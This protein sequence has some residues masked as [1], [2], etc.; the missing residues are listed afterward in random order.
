[1][2]QFVLC[3]E[4]HSLQRRIE[5]DKASYWVCAYANS[6]HDLSKDV[7]ED[8]EQSSFRKAMRLATGTLLM[9]DPAATAFK[10]IWCNFEL[11]K[12]VTDLNKLLDIATVRI[13][14]THA[15]WE[16]CIL[17]HGLSPKEASFKK[18]VREQRFPLELLVQGVKVRLE[19]GTATVDADKDHI[20]TCMAKDAA[21]DLQAAL[22]RANSALG[23]LIARAAWTQALRRGLVLDFDVHAPGT[24]SLPVV[25]AKDESCRFL[26]MTLAHC[27][28]VTDDEI[29]NLAQG[30]PPNIAEL[31]LSFEGC[32][33]ISDVGVEALAAR[34]PS[35]LHKL[36]LDFV[37]C[38]AVGDVGLIALAQALPPCLS[39]LHL[40]F[41]ACPH[42]SKRGLEVLARRVPNNVAVFSATFRGTKVDKNFGSVTELR[43]V[44]QSGLLPW[45]A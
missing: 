24:L 40:H 45:S 6:Q 38:R 22:R 13:S 33:R 42:V 27:E 25:L 23:G 20:L 12:T 21:G 30:F 1:M 32:D 9:L 34:L 28:N 36:T 7:T 3:C 29:A 10:R 2:L 4:A 41:A 31:I 44:F 43:A 26:Q 14:K 39:D 35:R 18:S 5:E 17:L 8:P 16:P 37:G 19:A 11:Y 15:N